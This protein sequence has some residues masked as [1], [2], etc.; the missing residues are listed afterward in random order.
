MFGLCLVLHR[1]FI[2]TRNHFP[3]TQESLSLFVI[4]FSSIIYWNGWQDSAFYIS[5]VFFIGYIKYP[6]KRIYYKITTRYLEFRYFEVIWLKHGTSPFLVGWQT[7]GIPPDFEIH[8]PIFK[9]NLT[10]PLFSS[11]FSLPRTVWWQ[12]CQTC[13]LS[14][15]T[16]GHVLVW[17]AVTDA[18]VLPSLCP[19]VHVKLPRGLPSH[20]HNGGS[21]FAGHSEGWEEILI[22]YLR[23]S[24]KG[25]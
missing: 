19:P 12:H 13:P 11:H 5:E 10:R 18:H 16:S 21:N 22:L 24:V 25:I 6:R 14:P 15:S 4:V 17:P 23:N 20:P 8:I 3:N 1:C 9:K 2:P 7:I